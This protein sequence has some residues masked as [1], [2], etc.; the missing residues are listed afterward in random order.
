MEEFRR[1][2]ALDS[3]HAGTRFALACCLDVSGH[4]I[5]ARREYA[6]AR[7]FD[8]LRFRT[9][10]DF[11]HLITEMEDSTTVGVADMERV[12]M[13]H[14]PDSLIGNE[15]VLEHV[16]PN[17]RGYFLMAGEFATGDAPP[18]PL[19]L[20]ARM[21]TERHYPGEHIVE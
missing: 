6:R 4:R 10:G 12:F 14:S 19:R 3:L 2:A 21:G 1:A 15:L 9:S 8:Q 7:D 17:S 20:S 13:I 18:R 11:N 16:H 5:E